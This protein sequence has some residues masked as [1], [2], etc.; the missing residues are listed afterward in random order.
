MFLKIFN[1]VFIYIWLICMICKNLK[2]I[3][4]VNRTNIIWELNFFQ[5]DRKHD[6]ISCSCVPIAIGLGK[7]FNVL[8]TYPCSFLRVSKPKFFKWA[9]PMDLNFFLRH[10]CKNQS[11]CFSKYNIGQRHTKHR[12]SWKAQQW[13]KAWCEW[14]L[15]VV[16]GWW[17]GR[18]DMTMAMQE[19][20]TK[21]GDGR[22]GV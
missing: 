2:Y 22:M 18:V 12:W 4:N 21:H 8:Q 16:G 19:L 7:M 14:K 13:Q 1:I 5:C 6:K 9:Y 20:D 3:Q 10:M 15:R 11:R 17:W